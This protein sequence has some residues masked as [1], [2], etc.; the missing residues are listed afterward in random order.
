M[1]E[2]VQTVECP[3][4]AP[5]G[6]RLV[7]HVDGMPASNIAANFDRMFRN[8]SAVIAMPWNDPANS[9]SFQQLTDYPQVWGSLASAFW[10]LTEG[11]DLGIAMELL[12]RIGAEYQIIPDAEKPDNHLELMMGILKERLQ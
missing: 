5:D 1:I 11:E 6:S 8:A 2:Q 3:K 4:S 7:F 12:N 9:L 10:L